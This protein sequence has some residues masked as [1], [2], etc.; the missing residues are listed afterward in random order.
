MLLHTV[1]ADTPLPFPI[2]TNL[3]S[4]S[5]TTFLMSVLPSDRYN[6]PQSHMA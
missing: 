1:E 4:V 6:L 3:H 2:L 5:T